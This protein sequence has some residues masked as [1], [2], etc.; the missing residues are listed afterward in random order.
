LFPAKAAAIGGLAALALLPAC[1]S[2]SSVRGCR[3]SGLALRAGFY[4]AA[5][6]QF[7]QTLTL[8]N[9]SSQTCRLGGW[10]RIHLVGRS[11]RT[12]RTPTMRVR[13]NAPSAP[14]WRSI[15]LR[16]GQAASFD[17]YGA[18]YDELPDVGCPK[19]AG[20]A[21]VV[22]GET[23]PM[24]VRLRVPYCGRFYVAPL[25]AGRSDRQSWSTVVRGGL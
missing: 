5:A 21:I 1:G 10:P 6:G 19:T 8:T 2:H 11:G 12:L 25:I 17:I 3:S 4:G 15:S 14:A 16:P 7:G 9:V 23:A 24:S 20:A 18:D 13:Q 22:P